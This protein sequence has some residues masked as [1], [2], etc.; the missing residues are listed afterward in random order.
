MAY[1]L[2]IPPSIL[3]VHPV[4]Y[5]SMLKKCHGDRDY[6]IHWNSELFDKDISYKEETIAILDRDMRKPRTKVILTMYSSGGIILLRRQRRRL[7][8]ICTSAILIKA[9]TI[10]G[11][12]FCIVLFS[13]YLWMSKG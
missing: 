5:V 7:R 4:F 9:S 13:Y 11:L 2:V 3:G 6:I 1:R 8:L 10:F 12:S